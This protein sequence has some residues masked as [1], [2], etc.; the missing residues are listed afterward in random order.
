LGDKHHLIVAHEVTN[1]GHDR[2][3]LSSM[4]QKAREATGRD[5]LTVLDRNENWTHSAARSERQIASAH[6]SA[7]HIASTLN[8]PSSFR[9][10]AVQN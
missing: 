7:F 6:L 10:A 8:G 1:V 4:A 5:K 2:G 9:T 3:Q